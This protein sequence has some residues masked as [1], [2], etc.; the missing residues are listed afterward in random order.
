MIENQ[1][2][3]G[4]VL[5]CRMSSRRLPGKILREI[6]GR[7]VMSYIEERIRRGAA[8]Y[9]LVV[10][11]S[12]EAAD[13]AIAAYCRR[14]G[15]QCFRGSLEDVAARLLQCAESHGWDY[16]VRIN[17]DN[18]F[19]D[20][21]T[22]G[23]MLAIAQLGIFDVVTNMP[24]RA[25]PYG[26]TVE[27]VRTA[28]Y[29][30]AM[31]KTNDPSHREHVTSYLYESGLGSQYVFRNRVCPAAAGLQLAL[32]TPEDLAKAETILE[33]AG[34]NPAALGL[35]Q[36]YELLRPEPIASPWQGSVGPLLIAEI[37]GNHEGDFEAAKRMARLAIAGGA[38]C[39]KFQL[40][41]G[42]T[43]VSAMESPDRHRHFQKFELSKD[44]HLE[45]AQIC[46][47][48]GVSY[49]ASVWDLEMLDWIDP[50]LD[51][52]K[53]GSGDLT[54]WPLIDEFVR[55]GKPILLSTGLA[56]MDEVL[57]TVR[58]IQALDK[59]YRRPEMLCVMQCTS[60]YPIQDDE[61]NLRVMDSLRNLTGV[62]IG[63]SDHTIGS[64]A[65]RAAAA[66][67][68]EAIEFH[69]TDRREGRTF[70]DHLVSL[71]PE[72]LR[73]LK[74]DIKQITTLRGS[75]VKTPQA[76]ELA[77]GHETSFRRGAYLRTAV[78]AGET[79]VKEN[80]VLLRPAHGTDARDVGLMLG[81]LALH[82]LEPLH[83]LKSGEDYA[84]FDHGRS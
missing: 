83:A 8:G 53:I 43:L 5:L 18:L 65:L 84:A 23:A 38:D 22:I 12:T 10:A 56:S 27:I 79:I 7:T 76:S 72:E 35:R 25:F 75:D 36:I 37:G 34:S 39:V 28:F 1:P 67:G 64:A 13:D 32:D 68:A 54:A 47:D 20:P 30:E 69:F 31:A 48:A 16:V 58:R 2:T 55:R 44:Q 41:R 46:R 73:Q 33:R 15:L 11:T 21:S 61:A 50:Y 71:N 4:I 52:Y 49:L 42:D 14:A 3:I 57:L 9:P 82:D 29:R 6:R 63:Y 62:A 17:G 45:L 26:M 60:M 77:A 70:R 81:A 74:I 66:M 40:Y 51:M 24:G 78:K 19:A 59:K 80:I